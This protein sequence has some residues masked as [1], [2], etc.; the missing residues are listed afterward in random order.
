MNLHRRV[1]PVIQ[2]SKPIY[3]IEDFKPK[4]IKGREIVGKAYN[5]KNEQIP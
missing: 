3:Q 4:S 2:F 5:S 1:L